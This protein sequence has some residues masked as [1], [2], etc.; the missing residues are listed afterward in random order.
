MRRMYSEK[1]IL[2]LVKNN[3]EA[4][5]RA[6]LGQDISV[7]GITSKGIANTGGLANIGDVAING[8]LDVSGEG[9][10]KVV[11][12]TLEQNEA[13]WSADITV[14]PNITGGTPSVIFGRAQQI[15]KEF[16]IVFLGKIVNNTE[17][18]IEAY[19]TTQVVIDLPENIAT[20]IYDVL[21]QKLNE[22]SAS[23]VRISYSFASATRS[24]YGDMSKLQPDIY[25]NV[26]RMNGAININKLGMQ[27]QRTTKI[28]IPA[29]ETLY[30]EGRVSLDLI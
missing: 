6:L 22:P 4:V 21:G 24:E 8:N 27:F 12:N 16:H 2:E 25:F 23:N 11:A 5:V 18:V 19:G 9:K 20:K 17:D 14:F 3:P 30:L 26:F 1:Q 7:E 15:N 28:S 29:G 13:N 10:G